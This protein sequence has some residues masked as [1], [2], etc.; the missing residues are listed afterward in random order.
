MKSKALWRSDWLPGTL[1]TLLFLLAFASAFSPLMRIDHLIYDQFAVTSDEPVDENIVLVHVDNQ[2]TDAD[3]DALAK[4]ISLLGSVDARVVALSR[5]FSHPVRSVSSQ[6]KSSQPASNQSVFAQAGDSNTDRLVEAVHR[7]GNVV[8]PVFAFVGNQHEYANGQLPESV[9]S[10]KIKHAIM[11]ASKNESISAASLRQ[12]YDALLQ[13]SAGLGH[14]SVF[15]DADGVVRSEP[16]VIAYGDSYFPS[17]PLTL[18]AR[19]LAIPMDDIRLNLGEDIELGAMDIA[20]DSATRIYPKFFSASSDQPFANYRLR[21]LLSGAIDPELFRDKVVLIGENARILPTPAGELSRMEFTAHVLQSML[22]EDYL[23]RPSWT[24]QAEIAL[25]L[26]TGLFL[27][28][29]LPRLNLL[30]GLAASAL[31]LA[32]LFSSGLVLLM[33]L[34]IW[35]QFGSAVLLLLS[36]QLILLLKQA[37]ASRQT[38]QKPASNLEETNKMLGFSFKSQGMLEQAL[39]KF[40]ACPVD[41]EMDAVLLDLAQGFERKRQYKHAV[42]AYERIVEHNPLFDDVQTRLARAKQLMETVDHKDSN[43]A[44]S[45]LLV[46][47]EN[48]PTL[49][50]YEILSELGKGAMGTVYLGKDPKIN[51]QVAIKTMALSQEFEADELEE[52]KAKF[53]HEAEIAGMLNHP[54]I[55]TIFDAGDEH[56][57]AYIAMEFLDGIDLVPYTKKGKLLPVGTTLKIVAKVAE[58]LKYAHANGVIHRDIKPANIMILK[59]KSVKVTD[60]GIAH[61]NESS[62]KKAGTVLGTP[63]YMSPEQ[64]SGKELDGRSDLFSL[65]VM[66]YELVSGVRP[67]RGESITK[68]MFKIAKEPHVDVREHNPAVPDCVATLVDSLLTKKA[69]LRIENAAIVMERINRC[70]RSLDSQGGAQG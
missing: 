52:V 45:S 26:L 25:L 30:I 59:N 53:F 61:I 15:G 38:Q 20:T 48:K 50:R 33:Q 55:V 22:K 57:L 10:L 60:F 65:G 31:L 69:D 14:M 58:A 44:L 40:L 37:V 49:G 21:D 12:P 8:M 39:E 23:S 36:G 66:L 29:L 35:L 9:Q 24:G 56:D 42:Q 51:R 54:N 27:I 17:M 34:N 47:G 5:L 13:A 70:L 28:L 18:A 3:S 62:K 16:L 7:A 43:T 68:L 67:F 1:L 19:A 11:T 32:V 41:D 6:P 64:L 46:S 2:S 63:S 4:A